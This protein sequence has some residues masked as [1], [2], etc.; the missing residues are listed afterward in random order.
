[1]PDL[2]IDATYA[3]LGTSLVGLLVI[4]LALRVPVAPPPDAAGLADT[5][6][7]VAASPYPSTAAHPVAAESIRLRPHRVALRTDGGT[8]HARVAYGPVT[9]VGGEPSLRRVLRGAPPPS[10]FD[11]PAEF[12][13]VLGDARNASHPWTDADGRVLVRAVSWEGVDATLVGR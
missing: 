6:D 7:S 4:G 2:P 13:R 3:W 11:S 5:I 8:A 1:M 9:P 10:V 12:R